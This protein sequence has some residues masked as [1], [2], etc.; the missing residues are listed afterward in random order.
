[1]FTEQEAHEA[2]DDDEEDEP[3]RK[4][5]RLGGVNDS[6]HNPANQGESMDVD[7][8]Q[9][10]RK[11]G[12]KKDKKTTKPKRKAAK[13]AICSSVPPFD[14]TDVM[15]DVHLELTVDQLMTMEKLP[16]ASIARAFRSPRR[17]KQTKA[18]GITSI[19]GGDDEVSAMALVTPAAIGNQEVSLILDSGLPILKIN[20]KAT[21]AVRGVHG[22]LCMPLGIYEG[23]PVTIKGVTVPT[24]VTVFDTYTYVLL[25]ETVW[26]FKAKTTI[27]L[28]NM[29]ATLEW[30]GSA[31]TVPVT[32]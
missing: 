15:R 18:A 19:P 2:S 24:D 6:M 4:K 10:K 25:V 11:T 30:T 32:C 21:K 3:G 31:L 7:G 1:V 29:T 12:T 27:N 17:V 20:K 13:P 5:V 16:R 23:L 14:F 26:L 9:S 28:K 22:K 8:E